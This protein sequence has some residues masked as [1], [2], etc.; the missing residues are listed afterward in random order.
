MSLEILLYLL[1]MLRKQ[2]SDCVVLYQ[3]AWLLN[4]PMIVVLFLVAIFV[5]KKTTEQWK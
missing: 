1:M 5:T 3:S 2:F 4:V